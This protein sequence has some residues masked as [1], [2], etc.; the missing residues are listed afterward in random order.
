MNMAAGITR[1]GRRQAEGLM[2]SRCVITAVTATSI[3]QATGLET[4]TTETI[5]AG[6]CRLRW[7][8][9]VVSEVNSADQYLAR[10]S[11]ELALPVAGTGMIRPD[12]I[13]TITENTLD[14][15]IV[16]LRLRVMGVQFQTHA[17]S[18]RLKLEVLS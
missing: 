15:S 11:P 12:H 16:G 5:Y 17:V 9:S 14:D 3:D 13:V 10:Q 4:V 18:R 2:D 1:F 6:P 8:S 7:V